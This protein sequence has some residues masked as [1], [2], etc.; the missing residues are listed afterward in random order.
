[1][2]EKNQSISRVIH[3]IYLITLDQ[4]MVVY[5]IKEMLNTATVRGLLGCLDSC[6]STDDSS[7][8]EI[9]KISRPSELRGVKSYKRLENKAFGA[10]YKE[11]ANRY[12]GAAGIS[13]AVSI[14]RYKGSRHRAHE[15]ERYKEY[16]WS[17]HGIAAYKTCKFYKTPVEAKVFAGMAERDIPVIRDNKMLHHGDFYLTSDDRQSW[18]SLIKKFEKLTSYREL[19]VNLKIKFANAFNCKYSDTEYDGRVDNRRVASYKC[20]ENDSSVL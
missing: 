13:G 11:K 18:R 15:I 6:K 10:I 8:Q 17:K 5:V 3:F 19:V 1:M 7:L 9:N 16:E 20:D 4:H 2:N 14:V 12:C